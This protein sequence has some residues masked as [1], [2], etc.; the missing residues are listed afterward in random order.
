MKRTAHAGLSLLAL[1][2]CARGAAADEAIGEIN[3]TAKRL[4]PAANEPMFATDTL[5]RATL[6]ESGA[7]RL[8]SALLTLPGFSLFRRQESRWSHPTTQGVT[9]R[10]LGPSGA[11]RTLVLLDGVPQN[12]PFGGWVDWSRLPLAAID[13]VSLTRGGGAGAWG[14]QALA[15]TIKLAHASTPGERAFG[16][17]RGATPGNGD[18][19]AA[20]DANVPSGT[21]RL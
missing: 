3:I 16:E 19:Y 12:D 18:L 14:D 15:G 1:L 13:Q 11:G 6:D 2:V 4:A 21:L 20:L 10:G 5:D 7:A 17:V 9:L 8:D